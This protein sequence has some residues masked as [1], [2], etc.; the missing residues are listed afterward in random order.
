MND[1]SIRDRIVQGFIHEFNRKGPKLT[2][3]DISDYLGM[4]KKTIYKSFKSKTAIYEFILKE[5]SDEIH[6]RQIAVSQDPSLSTK[7][8]LFK[9]LTIKTTSETVLDVARLA[10]VENVEP[11]FYKKLMHSYERQWDCFSN[12]VEIGKK[13]GTLKPDTSAQFL[14]ALLS[15]GYEMFYKGNFLASNHISY[16]NA[17]T[18]LAEIVLSGVYAK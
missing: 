9:I 5:T 2:M 8:K 1:F 10:E 4:A 7:E 13:D 11:E 18:K 3:Q 15:N 12:L 14:V 6:E 16:T 17:V